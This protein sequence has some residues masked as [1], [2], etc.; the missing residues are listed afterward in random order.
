MS[1]K[2]SDRNTKALL[3]SVMAFSCASALA[4]TTVSSSTTAKTL[5]STTGSSTTAATA[6]TGA[7][8]SS[9]TAPKATAATGSTTSTSTTTGTA[10]AAPASI[11]GTYLRPFAA[12]SPWN[13]RPVNPVLGTDVIPTSSY[14][15]VVTGGIFSTGIFL[16]KA[17][18]TP[19]TITGLY[20]AAGVDDADTLVAHPVTLPHWPAKTLPAT[21]S[22]GHADI[23]D[24]VTG[25]LHSLWQ[26]KNVN[27]KWQAKLYTWTPMAG[28]GWG[29]PAHFY[30]GARATGVPAA[31]GLIRAHE[32][33]D[34]APSYNHALAMSM[35]YNGLAP[36]YKY[37]ATTTDVD[38]AK[39]TG[40]IPQGSLVMLPANYDTSKIAS[41]PLRKVAETLKTYG[42]YVVDRNDG[43]PFA[44]NVEI[45]TGYDLHHGTWDNAVANELQRM[46][47]ALRPVISAS[48]WIDGDG[49]VT[50]MAPNLTENKLSM[51]GPWTRTSGT[52]TAAFDSWQQ[53][54]VFS[55]SPTK[56][57]VT[58]G[59]ST[60]LTKV[61]WATVASGTTQKFTV[62]A[63][64]GA[65]LRMQLYSG[66]T[67]VADSGN[68]G[69]GGSARM[70]WP[71]GAW[72]VLT[73][74]SGV[75]VESSVRGELSLTQ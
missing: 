63:T 57:V 43:T 21:G 58:N 4:Q 29:D 33:N 50:T 72:F 16:A 40:K 32:I 34:G 56:T 8:S 17:T 70:V 14:Y 42:A 51:R 39:N 44:I 1:S 28:K 52:G 36:G 48:S 41:L 60:G 25:I 37:P 54:V 62:S 75:N 59:N 35:T 15:P 73:A 24:E 67:V 68:L 64:G 65:T 20:G 3:I 7:T 5:A 9:T 38:S 12:N 66:S 13:S 55:A 53:A 6:S 49:K 74:T 26:L 11:W 10:T 27:G 30:H 19:M 31:A 69:N 18:D 47:A 71:A 61:T 2:M 23:Y 22:D 45:G 46:R